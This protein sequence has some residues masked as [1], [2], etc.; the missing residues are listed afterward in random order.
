MGK[1]RR[2]GPYTLLRRLGRGGMGEVYLADSRRGERVAVKLLRDPLS[3]SDDA[4]LR[5][6]REVRALRRVESPYVARV[7]DADLIGERP[8]LVME[9]IDGDTLLERVRRSGP[10]GRAELVALAQR[11][12][13]ALA[14]IHAAGVV[15]RDLKP[16]NVLL[17]PDGPILID[18]GI[19]HMLDA[20]RLTMTGTFL[21]TPG[22]AAPELFADEPVGEPA[23]VHAWA[24]T[25]AFAATGRPTFGRGTIEAQMYA[26]LNGEA[27]LAGVPAALLP[28]IKAALN[29]TPSKRPTAA[30]LADRLTRLARATAIPVLDDA[31]GAAAAVVG[32]SGEP[33]AAPHLDAAPAR[34]A[35][36]RSARETPAGQAH[37][38]MPETGQR[39]LAEDPAHRRGPEDG[40]RRTAEEAAPRR[41][42][43]SQPG[44]R[45]TSEDSQ[46]VP[47]RAAEDSH[48]SQRGA[49]DSHGS[50]R[51]AEDS[52][53]SR[54]AGEDSYGSRRAGEDSY[55]SRRAGEDS[56]G[57]RRAGEDS[58]GSRRAGEDSYGSRRVVEEQAGQGRRRPASAPPRGG[59]NGPARRSG[60]PTQAGTPALMVLAVLAVPC[61][62]GSVIWPP[63]AFGVTGLST[64]LARSAWMGH[65]MVRNHRTRGARWS[66]R[67]LGFPFA[68]TASAV[69]AVA[70]PGVPAA[71]AAGLSLWAAAGADLGPGWWDKPGPV[72]LAGV[73][74]GVVCGWIV[75]R[76][77]E[78]VGS[79]L[80]GLRKE[81]LRAFAVLGG[82]V[83]VCAAAVRAI[84]LLF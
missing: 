74:F 17:G 50:R 24:A 35:A 49:E 54:R 61:V 38:S 14:M 22:Y 77:V 2:V 81:G 68:F 52:Y 37:H 31:G 26:I 6:E 84:A 1:L 43:D 57:S 72:T 30:L 3:D 19:A 15:H 34:Q 13:V 64:V 59:R 36:A 83:A 82:F 7:L 51:A 25:V 58:Y 32:A 62:V 45:R 70:W 69:S 60:G 39:R 41:A 9:H 75:G 73:V 33:L 47:R 44:Q 67:V 29:R 4:R 63:A 11:M 48:G 28:L 55:G 42:E 56:Y 21:G 71:G 18:F 65:W 53:G 8:Y 66:R 46:P 16:A 79:A 20:T 23:D 10:F 78:R 5:L 12:A 76:E 27:D 80:P 40:H